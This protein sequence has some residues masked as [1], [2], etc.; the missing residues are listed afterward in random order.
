M[1]HSVSQMRHIDQLLRCRAAWRVCTMAATPRPLLLQS[2]DP[3]VWAYIQAASARFILLRAAK[4]RR[5]SAFCL[6]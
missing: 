1:V 2:A 6:L 4:G 5:L 3:C